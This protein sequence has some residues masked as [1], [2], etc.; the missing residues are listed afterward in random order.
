MVVRVVVRVLVRVL[1]CGRL[2]IVR[3]HHRRGR[4]SR[5]QSATSSR[6]VRS[7]PLALSKKARKVRLTCSLAPDAVCALREA[8]PSLR[9]EEDAVELPAWPVMCVMILELRSLVR[10]EVVH[11]H[12]RCEMNERESTMLHVRV[13][14]A[15]R[16]MML[17][18]HVA[19]VERS[20]APKARAMAPL[21]RA[22]EVRCAGG[23]TASNVFWH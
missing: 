11:V 4:K 6:H 23:A 18:A 13:D 9:R 22:H 3:R 1:V 8:R 17:T 20:R 10:A 12:D 14:E 2:L 19:E 15:A 16:L 5:A 21:T 7:L